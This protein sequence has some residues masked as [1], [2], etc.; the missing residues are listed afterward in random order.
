MALIGLV[1]AVGAAAGTVSVPLMPAQSLVMQTVAHWGLYNRGQS[2]DNDGGQAARKSARPTAGI[3]RGAP[4]SNTQTPGAPT[5]QGAPPGED[6]R[7]DPQDLADIRKKSRESKRQQPLPPMF[8]CTIRVPGDLF[9]A[10]GLAT[11]YLLATA[12]DAKA[13]CHEGD[14]NTSAFV[15]AVIL[16]PATG[17]VSIYNPLVIDGGTQ[18]AVAPTLP[19]LPDRAIVAVWFGYNGDNLR[20]VGPGRGQ[21]VRGIPGSIFGQNAFCGTDLFWAA[22]NAL[23]RVGRLKPA[24]LGTAKDGKPCPTVR[25][26]SIVDQDQSDNT[27]TQYLVTIDGRT[28]QDTPANRAKLPGATTQV[29]GSDER[30]T[31]IAVDGALAC[32]PWTARDLADQSA[33]PRM[34]PAWPLNEL[35]AAMNQAPPV[36]TIPALDPFA[37]ASGQPNLRKLNLYRAGVN[38]PL[39]GSLAQADTKTYC[40][41]LLNDGLPRVAADR[42]YTGVAKSP[43]PD[44]ATTLFNFLALRFNNTWTNLTCDQLLGLQNPVTVTMDGNGVV[45]DASIDLNPPKLSATPTAS[46]AAASPTPILS[47]TVTAPVSPAPTVTTSPAPPATTPAITPTTTPSTKTTPN[48]TTT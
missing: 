9:T 14:A 35:D 20:L 39:V 40:G 46:P 28:A 21:C 24:P 43:F 45:T 38:Q 37:M 16:D 11:P 1:S 6:D 47:P 32:V 41:H 23:V 8:N 22:A 15:Q 19:R 17:Q 36:A 33:S 5:D 7:A 2:G 44:L 13:P 29:N 48:P 10:H 31:S 34:L 26:F 27:T 30:L 12:P 42:P 25:D 18:P 3:I 4:G